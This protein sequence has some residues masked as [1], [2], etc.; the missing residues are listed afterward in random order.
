MKPSRNRRTDHDDVRDFYNSEYYQQDAVGGR[1]PWQVRRIAS[2]ISPLPGC[3]VLDIAC[4]RGEWLEELAS[5]GAHP[6]GI[7]ISKC[8][9]AKARIRIPSADLREG[10]AEAL[11]FDDSSFDLVT[12]LG[13]LEHFLDQQKALS[14]MRRVARP[15]ARVLILV[16]NAGF[17]TR[18]LGLYRGTGQVAIRETVR[19]IDEWTR[20]LETA[21]LEVISRWRDLHPLSL[22]WITRGNSFAWP[23]RAAQAVALAAW[24]MEW[25]YQVYFSCRVPAEAS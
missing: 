18:R 7:D 13:S 20:M 22:G 3:V 19:S 5:R 8:A 21:G 1:L 9:I 15:G 23:L 11:P 24:P 4:G 2:R 17:L 12:C 16:P 10:I 14:E 25:Q 6:V